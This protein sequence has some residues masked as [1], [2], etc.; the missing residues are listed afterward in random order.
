M[1]AVSAGTLLAGKYRLERVIGRGGMGS[2]WRAEHL[3]LSAPVAVKVLNLTEIAPTPEAL[4]RFHREARAAASVRSPHV[5]QVLDH[6]V[7]ETSNA[8]YIVMELLEGE[9]LAVRLRRVGRISPEETMLILTHVARALARAHEAGIVHR[10]LKPDNVFLVQNEE[11]VVAKV[12]DFGIAKTQVFGLDA[13]A[14]TRTGAVM[15]TAY[16]MSPEQ[17][18]GSRNLDLRTDLWAFAVMACECLTGQRPF[19]ADSIGGLTLVICLEPVRLPSSLAPVPAGFD[20]WFLRA[21]N[22]DPKQRFDSA[23]EAAE[24]LRLALAIPS[25]GLRLSISQPPD[26]SG[27]MPPLASTIT[28]GVPFSIKTRPL[29]APA[30]TPPKRRTPW[31]AGGA[32]VLVAGGVIWLTRG[33]AND[34]STGAPSASPSES[35]TTVPTQVELPTSSGTTKTP[36]APEAS[37]APLAPEPASTPVPAPKSGAHPAAKHPAPKPAPAL[38]TSASPAA[39]PAAAPPAPAPAPAPIERDVL[40]DRH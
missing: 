9:S 36:P 14:A 35:R 34:H 20:A 10:D 31:L 38:P 28:T 26:A 21:V 2:V 33:L 39:P 7:D 24:A 22:R 8:P 40:D 11:E 16:Y 25:D 3:G 5:V 19:V 13:E 27:S 30:P 4:Q 6:G 32:A 17:I 29:V 1:T 12:V 37:A 23:R 18:S 15:G